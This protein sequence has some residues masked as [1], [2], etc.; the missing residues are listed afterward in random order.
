VRQGEIWLM[1]S[2]GH[3][4][5]PALILQRDAALAVMNRV[6]VAP[7]TTTIRNLPTCLPLGAAEGLDRECVA[8]LDS[9]AVIPKYALTRRLGDIGNRR[10]EMCTALA[11]LADC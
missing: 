7:V 5:R 8:N 2:P 6:T 1:E 9:I 10:H 11:A 3:K 4:A